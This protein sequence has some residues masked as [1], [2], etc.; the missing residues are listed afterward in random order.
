MG[1]LRVALGLHGYVWDFK[2]TKMC[3]GEE[4]H[5]RMLVYISCLDV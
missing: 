5:S 2:R 1:K 3:F 4:P